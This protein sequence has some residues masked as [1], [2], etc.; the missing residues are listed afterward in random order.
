MV[1][2]LK[3]IYVKNVI[4]LNFTLNNRRLLGFIIE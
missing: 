3:R 1:M 4:G 2:R